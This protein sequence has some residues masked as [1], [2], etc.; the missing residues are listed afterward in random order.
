MS[1]NFSFVA[2]VMY[3][4]EITNWQQSLPIIRQHHAD[5]SRDS[6]LVSMVRTLVLIVSASYAAYVGIVDTR[7][8]PCSQL[9]LRA[10]L[11]TECNAEIP[12]ALHW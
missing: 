10:F 11:S 2:Q 6:A 5:S 8:E 9:F 12:G 4:P 3:L 1:R 7:A